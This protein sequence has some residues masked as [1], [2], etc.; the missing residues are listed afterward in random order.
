MHSVEDVDP[1]GLDP[2]PDALAR[3]SRARRLDARKPFW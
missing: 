2:K 3:A 1:L